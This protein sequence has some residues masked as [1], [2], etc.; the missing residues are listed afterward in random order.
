MSRSR[1]K[2]KDENR[3]V[4]TRGTITKQILDGH[5]IYDLV[6]TLYNW[7]DYYDEER[8]S[9]YV[10]VEEAIRN[11]ADVILDSCDTVEADGKS[12][13][14]LEDPDGDN[15]YWLTTDLEEVKKRIL[16][17]YKK[18]GI[19]PAAF[20]P[21]PSPDTDDQDEDDKD[22]YRFRDEEDDEEVWDEQALDRE[23]EDYN[24]FEQQQKKIP[25]KP[26]KK[27]RR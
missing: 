17:A 18:C 16:A 22:D 25:K 27:Q 6:E 19:D 12:Y 15:A 23:M 24:D 9:K 8:D 7:R 5:S 10:K 20:V 13:T 3:F 4:L 26:K 11:C 14:W 1:S 21:A 2:P